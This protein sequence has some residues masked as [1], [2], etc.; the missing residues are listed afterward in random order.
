MVCTCL[1]NYRIAV[2]ETCMSDLS[3]LP[4]SALRKAQ[5]ALSRA[6]LVNDSDD[7][8]IGSA[9]GSDEEASDSEPEE[10]P[11]LADAK[12]K[13]KEKKEGRK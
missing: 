5:Q 1:P 4:L 2:N 11:S 8:N 12:A 7:E 9:E 6:K 10:Q 3:S 13:E